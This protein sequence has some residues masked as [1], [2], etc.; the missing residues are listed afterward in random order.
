MLTHC[1]RQKEAVQST[2]PLQGQTLCGIL[3]YPTGDQHLYG[4][5]AY[6]VSKQGSE[7]SCNRCLRA[8]KAGRIPAQVIR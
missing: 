1:L 8:L 3:G 4:M 2:D 7:V 5:S 6:R